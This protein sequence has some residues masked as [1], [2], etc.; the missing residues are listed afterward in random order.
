V[1]K[2]PFS[3]SFQGIFITALTR[4]KV[5]D[6]ANRAN[7]ASKPGTQLY[8]SIEHDINWKAAS[9]GSWTSVTTVEELNPKWL[10]ADASSSL[11]RCAKGIVQAAAQ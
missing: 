2:I 6:G 4:L 8:L 7:P 5:E 11:A 1:Q 10:G 9:M 3:A